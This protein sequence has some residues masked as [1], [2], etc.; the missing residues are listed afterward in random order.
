MGLYNEIVHNK[1]KINTSQQLYKKI[2]FNQFLS[3]ARFTLSFLIARIFFYLL[4]I[5]IL[6]SLNNSKITIIIYC[7]ILITFLILVALET[8]TFLKIST[9]K[10]DYLK[11][12]TSI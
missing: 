5:T 4:Q 8:F 2:Y 11:E 1:P 7:I 6:D 12:L 10:E 3:L 9:D